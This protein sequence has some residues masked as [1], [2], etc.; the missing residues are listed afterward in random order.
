[1]ILLVKWEIAFNDMWITKKK[2]KIS[3]TIRVIRDLQWYVGENKMSG[4]KVHRRCMHIS[5]QTVE[6]AC[7]L[8]KLSMK[9]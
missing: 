8:Q 4:C 7:E 6:K 9:L 2:K 1:M 3:L 5:C